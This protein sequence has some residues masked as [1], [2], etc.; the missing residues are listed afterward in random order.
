MFVLQKIVYW[1]WD[2]ST[3]MNWKGRPSAKIYHPYH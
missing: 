2:N 3:K 1:W